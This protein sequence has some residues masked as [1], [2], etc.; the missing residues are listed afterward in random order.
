[1]IYVI[2]CILCSSVLYIIFK[3]FEIFKIDLLQAIVVNYIVASALGFVIAVNYYNPATYQPVFS[4]PWWPYAILI[5]L[6]F[7]S[8]FNLMGISSQKSG[9]S[10]TSVAN[11]M[12]VVLP[13]IFGFAFLQEK[14]TGL[15]IAGILLA[16][17]ALY[18]VTR[19]PK[20]KQGS[21]LFPVI[22]FFA[23]GVLDIILGYCSGKYVYRENTFQFTACL[24]MFAAFFG[25]VYLT[26]Q[27]IGGKQKIKSRNIL[28]GIILGIPNFGSIVFVFKG[29]SATGWDV[30]VFYPVLNMG[31]VLV[32]ALLAFVFFKEKLSLIN[33]AGVGVAILAIYLMAFV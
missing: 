20:D 15:R 28:A 3:A 14:I 24:F 8:I 29:L 7:I 6:M 19:K 33:L 9:V 23:S 10:V 27:V 26:I 17:V 32:A 16:L 5:G 22:I 31:T 12:S 25:S 18:F 1:M 11:K 4:S 30:S 21:L 13:V 2:A